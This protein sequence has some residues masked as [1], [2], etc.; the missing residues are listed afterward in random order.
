MWL[1]SSPSSLLFILLVSPFAFLS[2]CAALSH[3]TACS[4]SPEEERD[5]FRGEACVAVSFLVNTLL[6]HHHHPCLFLLLLRVKL[7]FLASL[8]FS[9][10]LYFLAFLGFFTSCFVREKEERNFCDSPSSSSS[11]SS[12]LLLHPSL[13]P[14]SVLVCV[15]D[16]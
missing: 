2:L 6:V 7:T 14:E 13:I 5:R 3:L 9:L 4:V 11:S 10:S 15:H 8:H 1:P 12:S 16:V